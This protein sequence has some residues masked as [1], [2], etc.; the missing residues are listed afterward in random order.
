MIV[1]SIFGFLSSIFGLSPFMACL[2]IYIL[3]F[4]ILS[5]CLEYQDQVFTK[6]YVDVIRKEAHFLITPS[7]RA[8]FYFFVGVLMVAK[9]GLLDLFAGL[10][11]ILV[12]VVI[13]NSCR[14]AYLV[15]NELHNAKYTEAFIIAKFRE[16]D[17]DKSGHLDT[18]ELGLV[19]NLFTSK[20]RKKGVI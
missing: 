19:S 20:C 2:D 13:Y 11:L 18:K 1:T 6:K 14:N 9:G 17:V 10:F 7:G 3:V 16:F 8:A 5:V 4:G 15:F 12:G